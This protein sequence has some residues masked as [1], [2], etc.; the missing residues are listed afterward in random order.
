MSKRSV[1]FT[2][3]AWQQY[4]YWQL[5]DSRLLPKINNLIEDILRDPFR[6]LGKQLKGKLSSF[7][8][9]RINEEHRL[10]YKLQA[11]KV[12]ITSC[13]YHYNK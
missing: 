8:S 9:R 4:V 7:W 6:G 3:E 1:E 13:R 5:A 11:D 12:S 10:V 2:P